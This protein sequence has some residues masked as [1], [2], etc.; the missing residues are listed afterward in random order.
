MADIKN[1]DGPYYVLCRISDLDERVELAAYPA[2][3]EES[4]GR[5]L[6]EDQRRL[7]PN[8]EAEHRT[9]LVASPARKLSL[10][11]LS[12]WPADEGWQVCL[13]DVN[14]AGDRITATICEGSSLSSYVLSP[15][16]ASAV[17]A[18]VC[19]CDRWSGQPVPGEPLPAMWT[20][21]KSRDSKPVSSR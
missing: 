4:A 19:R 16:Q 10:G 17:F 2:D 5:L 3:F 13:L 6:D 8:G 11:R 21:G 20:D 15:Q 7:S 1:W 18:S 9:V 14:A 12:A